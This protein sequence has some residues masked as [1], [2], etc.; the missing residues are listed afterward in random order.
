MGLQATRTPSSPITACEPVTR[1]M[2]SQRLR[3]ALRRPIFSRDLPG[4]SGCARF[5]SKGANHK[6]REQG[7]VPRGSKE[8]TGVSWWARLR[9][10]LWTALGQANSASHHP[11]AQGRPTE[12][13][14]RFS[15][16][17]DPTLSETAP[18]GRTGSR[19]QG[20][21]VPGSGPSRS[22]PV[23]CPRLVGFHESRIADDIGGKDGCKLTFHG[24]APRS[25]TRVTECRAEY[26]HNPRDVIAG[27][28][29]TPYPS[30][31]IG[32]RQ[33]PSSL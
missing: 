23:E 13:V 1:V 16:F 5:G 11:F 31:L 27:M 10:H 2:R 14:S 19:D 18:R 21:R 25:V 20:G 22:Q 15:R 24:R 6:R 9:S 32:S 17:C 12:A 30:G 33:N 26:G 29:S 8:L 3:P 28:I 7:G 4:C